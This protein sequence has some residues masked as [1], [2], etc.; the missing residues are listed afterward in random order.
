MGGDTFYEGNAQLIL[1][2]ILAQKHID[3][4][5]LK[6]ETHLHLGIGCACSVEKSYLC[7]IVSAKDIVAPITSE[8]LP[9]F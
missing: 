5:I 2:Y 9:I 8:K 1:E 3:T 7:Y 6:S 4:S